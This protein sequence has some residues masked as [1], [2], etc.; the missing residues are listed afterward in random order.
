MSLKSE[1]LQNSINNHKLDPENTQ[2]FFVNKF[3][4]I[5]PEPMGTISTFSTYAI[6]EL[7]YPTTLIIRG[8]SDIPVAA[9]LQD[10]FGLKPNDNYR[11]V[12]FQRFESKY[13]K[14]T[15]NFY[16]QAFRYIVSKKRN[17]LQT[18]V[19]S[20]NTT[21]LPYLLMLRKLHNVITIFETH[22][23][24]GNLTLPGLPAAP[25]RPFLKSSHTFQKL[26]RIFLNHIHGL[27]CITGPQKRLYETDFVKTP[28]I[29]LP[30]GGN[31][32]GDLYPDKINTSGKFKSKRVCYIGRLNAHIDYKTV[33]EAMS[34]L[35]D[36][37]INFIWIGLKDQNFPVL[38]AEINRL[39][40]SERVELK[41]WMPHKEMFA[42]L[43]ERAGVGLAAYKPTYQSTVYTNPSKIFDY[44]AAGLPVIAPRMSNV[45]DVITDGK[46]GL[47]F[48][49]E[50]S[51]S[52]AK[53]I[54]YLFK[55]YHL[56]EQLQSA[57]IESAREYSWER[58]A[59][60]LMEFIETFI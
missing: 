11:I 41:G 10:E 55:N 17:N 53:T 47:L 12:L 40:I 44:F 43:R 45:E 15:S 42:Y 6:A 37:D 8:N 35:D 58:R 23:Y 46:N 50:N 48:Q 59:E 4:W 16:F 33:L 3:S 26:E 19:I 52:L 36:K 29:F 32:Y 20:R 28:A 14:T 30:L 5:S 13:F 49:P 24:H 34:I 21:F 18:V 54:A 56:Y 57:S 39:N 60:R 2:V 27:V 25:R 1:A 38:K 31:Q 9:T 51:R 22:G 7:G